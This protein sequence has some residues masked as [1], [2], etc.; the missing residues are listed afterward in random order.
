MELI[1]LPKTYEEKGGRFRISPVISCGSEEL[2]PAV[3]VF[4]D[5]AEKAFGRAWSL[6][7]AENGVELELCGALAEEGY[8]LSADGRRVVVSAS[9]LPGANRAL[10][11]LL[12]LLDDG[13]TLPE[14][15][16]SDAPDTS[17]RKSS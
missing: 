4:S 10:A 12:Q 11:T 8:S 9:S 13:L 2:L 1:P 17:S 15:G 16:I 3:K 6:G 5:Y 14:C 7:G